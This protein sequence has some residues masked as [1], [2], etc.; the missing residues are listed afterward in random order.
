MSKVFFGA[1][2]AGT[3]LKEKIKQA[4]ASDGYDIEDLSPSMPEGGDDYP[5]YA[6]LVGEQVA[7][8]EESR[9]ILVCDTG[10]GMAI[11]A[12]KVK[13]IR[14]A[15]VHNVFSA[16][17][18]REHNDANV[19]V[20][21]SELIKPADAIEAARYFMELVYPYSERHNRRIGKIKYYE[22]HGQIPG[23]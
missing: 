8:D 19:L 22:T 21:G 2:H 16:K 1:D 6:F 14:A 23:K 4:L 5:D 12:N 17:K 3:E 15:L 10:I 9:G 11:A 7:S 13:N 20:F 18:S